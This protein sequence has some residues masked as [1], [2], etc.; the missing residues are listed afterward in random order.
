MTVILAASLF[1]CLTG[2]HPLWNGL[3]MNSPRRLNRRL[4]HKMSCFALCLVF[5][6]SQSPAQQPS[7][8]QSPVPNKTRNSATTNT[9]AGQGTIGLDPKAAEIMKAA[10]AEGFPLAAE[11]VADNVSV[12]AVLLPAEVCK[13][14]FGKEIAENFAA[15]ELTIS[16][17]SSKD[18]LILHSVFIDYS[19]WALSGSLYL[20][21]PVVQ[22]SEANKSHLPSKQS[23]PPSYQASS[24]PNQISSVWSTGSP[25]GTCSMRNLGRRGTG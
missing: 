18:A 15:V 10:N 3:L 19:Q 5:L 20:K 22:A 7:V 21:P 6:Q 2:K 23:L 13:R 1:F 17:R 24:N 8:Q 25:E 4:I 11:T 16:N 12:E 14:V 9:A